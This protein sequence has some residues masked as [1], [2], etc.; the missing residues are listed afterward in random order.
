LCSKVRGD[1]LWGSWLFWYHYYQ[2]LV[3]PILL[4]YTYHAKLF[5]FWEARTPSKQWLLIP[6]L[7]YFQIHNMSNVLGKPWHYG[8]RLWCSLATRTWCASS[9]YVN[10]WNL[11]CK[12]C[13]LISM[14]VAECNDICRCFELALV[15]LH[16][17]IIVDVFYL[18][19]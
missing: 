19:S 14:I 7:S 4:L 17:D 15:A 1:L 16:Q 13:L 10:F 8:G 9:P 11:A 6:L 18:M 12:P 3:L 5:G 2:L